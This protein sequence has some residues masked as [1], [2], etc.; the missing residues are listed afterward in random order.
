MKKQ[1][2]GYIDA[3]FDEKTKKEIESWSMIV[4]D[5]DLYTISN[6]NKKDGGNITD[7]L[8]LT[9]FYGFDENL[10]NMDEVLK[11]IDNIKLD[12]VKINGLGTFPVTGHNC[13]ILFLKVDDDE[14]II[15]NIHEEL[16][17]FPY[18]SEYQKLKFIPHIAIA[19]IRNDL[20]T[21]ALVYS[22]PSTLSVK[23][24]SYH[25]KFKEN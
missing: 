6:E 11:F 24:I 7:K 3:I 18:F 22:N 16:K 12:I 25:S 20:N 9:L 5:E 14:D 21:N 8:H 15:K 10:L 23:K 13:K 2:I 17:K 1:K 4:R 19:F